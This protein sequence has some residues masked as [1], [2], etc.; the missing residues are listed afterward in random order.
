MTPSGPIVLY[1][2]ECALCD[3]T[4]HFLVRRDPGR[5]L[6][7]AALQSEAGRA[8]L[9]RHGLPPDDLDTMVLV[10]DGAAHVRSTGVLRALRHLRRPWPILAWLLAVP[11]PIRDLA[12]RLVAANRIRVFGR[13]DACA[14]PPTG[15]REREVRIE[16]LAVAD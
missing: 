2:G 5:R 3:G 11:R 12:Y 6:R 9:A 16:D 14:V 10:E 7:F 13:P 4:V 15:W 1:D 8:L